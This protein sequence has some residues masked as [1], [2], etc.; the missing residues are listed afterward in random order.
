MR[1]KEMSKY[2]ITNFFLLL[3]S[4]SF[5]FL[6][7][8]MGDKEVLCG[9]IRPFLVHGCK[10]KPALKNEK[11]C[12]DHPPT[13]ATSPFSSHSLERTSTSPY[14]VTIATNSPFVL[15]LFFKK[16]ARALK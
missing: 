3:N 8:K 15:L 14:T 6:H 13:S 9:K 12:Y 11:L 4:L 10:K 16:T 1:G 5:D 7:K 2:Y